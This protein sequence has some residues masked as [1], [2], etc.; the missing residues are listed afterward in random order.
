MDLKSQ[1]KALFKEAELY[2]TQ[3]LLE[4]AKK[5]Y[6]LVADLIQENEGLSNRDYLLDAL[7]KKMD[8]VDQDSE[9]INEA[10]RAPALSTKV[11]DLIKKLFSFS[12]EEDKD[13][14]DLEGAIALAKFGQFERA[15]VEFNKLVKRDALR[16]VAAKNVIRCHVAL[17]DF[18]NASNQFS[19]WRSS[20]DFSSEELERV[21][22]FLQEV[23]EKKGVDKKLIPLAER[24]EEATEDEVPSDELL[25]IV[26]IGMTLVRGSKKGRFVELDVNF[27]RGNTISLMISG[28]DRDLMENLQVGVKLNEVEFSSPFAVFKGAGVVSA[29]T[30]IDA[31]PKQGDYM[32]DI[33]IRGV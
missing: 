2:R 29:K 4:E 5:K 6:S 27:Q 13:S 7:G 21:R 10:S 25:D 18:E 20:V 8:A 24:T 23:L 11:Q 15:I 14:S 32:L 12:G 16:V 1:I 3:G 9:R 31:G 30:Q 22:V 17:S 19:Q 28:E 26:S 33:K